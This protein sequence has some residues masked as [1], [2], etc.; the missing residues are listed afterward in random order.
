MVD[1]RFRPLAKWPGALDKTKTPFKMDFVRSLDLLEYELKKLQATGIVIE[2]G[3]TIEQLRNDGWPRPGQMPSHPGVIL[4]FKAGTGDN[5]KFPCGTYNS[6]RANLHAI[7]LTLERLRDIDR[8]G[9]TLIHQQYI[10]FTALPPA[11]AFTVESAAE[12]LYTQS[13]LHEPTQIL[14]SP[15]AY[16]NA[17]RDAASRLHPDKPGTGNREL[18]EQ[19]NKARELLDAHHDLRTTA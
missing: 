1:L 19:L 2:A 8:Y 7:A 9:V 4:Y 6:Y 12:F 14:G 17:F 10:G 15:M 16:P 3:F 13:R 11:G 5:L 18:W